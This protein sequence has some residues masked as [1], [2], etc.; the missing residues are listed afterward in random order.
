M[1]EFPIWTA[2][3]RQAYLQSFEPLQREIHIA[4]P[5]KEFNLPHDK[6]L[7]I[8]KPL[9]GLCD[10]GDLWYETLDQHHR[11]N[12]KMEPFR[13]DTALYSSGEG[14][15]LKGLS[16]CY[17]DD[18]LR[19][20]NFE[21]EK[22]SSKTKERI[23][24][25]ESFRLQS[26][27]TGFLIDEDRHSFF[28][29]QNNYLRKL[30]SL[31]K[32]AT[33]GEFQSMRMKLAWLSNS[34][35]N[36]LFEIAQLAQITDEM[37]K[38]SAPT[39]IRRLHKATK[40]AVENRIRLRIPTLEKSSIRVVG[41]SDS[42]FANNEDYSSQLGYIIMIVDQNNLAAPIYIRSYKSRRV[43]RSALSA[44]VI[45]FSDMFDISASLIA[46]LSK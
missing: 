23:E 42:S 39:I 3:V 32:D 4:K 29:D 5:A 21:F 14:D 13:I 25:A 27:F 35:Q 37:F 30:E 46:E 24:L 28:I 20:G 17:V 40:Y 19:C 44:E 1:Y 9:Y 43:N 41:F 18:L 33:F 22:A 45:A 31:P 34:R 11:K 8:V 26:E 16:G 12:L 2:D 10:A 36:C 38:K 7:K 6:C 15:N